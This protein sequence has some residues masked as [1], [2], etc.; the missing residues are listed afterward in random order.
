MFFRAVAESMLV[1]VRWLLVVAPIGVFALALPLVARLG[2]SAVG[3]LVTYVALVSLVAVLF[4]LLVLYRRAR[5]AVASRCASSR[6][7]SLRRRPSRFRR[8]R[9][10]PRCPR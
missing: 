5:G 2:F 8:D 4:M 9:R 1:I 10:S 7:L 6:A 3:A